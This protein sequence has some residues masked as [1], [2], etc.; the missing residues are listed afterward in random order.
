MAALEGSAPSAAVGRDAAFS[1]FYREFVPT[2]V[3]SM[4]WQGARLTD[5]ADAVQETM[6]KAYVVWDRLDNPRAW[7]YTVAF[8]T[9]RRRAANVGE[10][11]VGEL[12]EPNPL[13]PRATGIA[14]WEEQ[15]EV[16]RVLALLPERQRQVLAWRFD[17]YTPAEIATE[18]MISPEAARASLAKARR[19]L[20]Q[21]LQTRHEETL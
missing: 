15:H 9:W 17:G 4:T 19:A 7:A 1:A 8:R 13:L 14:A 21:Y 20:A 18:L 12:P 10:D 2:L 11:P 5:A 6:S 3:A 16:L